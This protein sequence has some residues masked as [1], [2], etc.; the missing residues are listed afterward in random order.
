MKDLYIP[1]ESGWY[2]KRSEIEKIVIKYGVT[3][4]GDYVFGSHSNLTSVEIPNSVIDIGK[5]AFRNCTSLESVEIPNSVLNVG[6]YAFAKC[7]SLVEVAITNCIGVGMFYG[8]SNL[9]DI[10]ILDGIVSIGDDAFNGC[11]SLTKIKIPNSV[12][13]IGNSAFWGCTSLIE[14][15]VPNSVTVIGENAFNN[16]TSLTEIE[17]PNSVNC[18]KPY[19][20]CDCSNLVNVKIPDGVQDIGEYA[21]ADCIK[22]VEIKIPDHVTNIG[23]WAFDGCYS[24]KS[25]NIPQNLEKINTATFRYCA[26]TDIKIPDSVTS[27]GPRA[28]ERTKI[29]NVIIPNSV[30]VIEDRAFEY[31]GLTSAFIPKSVSNI[32]DYVFSATN[33]DLTIYGY[34][35]SYAK[36]FSNQK[37]ISFVAL[38]EGDIPSEN[39]TIIS[40]LSE[41][42]ELKAGEDNA[43]PLMYEITP[44]SSKEQDVTWTIADES[45]IKPVD[46]PVGGYWI[47]GLKPGTTTITA[48]TEDGASSTRTIT[49]ANENIGGT[50]GTTINIYT[51]EEFVCN[52]GSTLEVQANAL[53]S[54]PVEERGTIT[55]SI[56]NPA[57]L[58]EVSVK[59]DMLKG[60]STIQVKGLQSGETTLTATTS[61]GAS[62]TKTVK[63][64][65]VISHDYRTLVGT[66]QKYDA[67]TNQIYV[68]GSYYPIA[69]TVSIGDDLSS[70]NVTNMIGKQVYVLMDNGKVVEFGTI[71]S[72]KTKLDV[73]LV[74]DFAERN[75]IYQNGHYSN[76]TVPVTISIKNSVQLSG[77]DLSVI[78]KHL[79]SN[80]SLKDLCWES[81]TLE[82]Q[83]TEGI[84]GVTLAPN[85]SHSV[86]AILKIPA[87][88]V[89]ERVTEKLSGQAI[90]TAQIK[91]EACSAQ[92]GIMISVGNLDLQKEIAAVQKEQREEQKKPTSESIKNNA[93]S[94]DKELNNITNQLILPQNLDL[95]VMKD[96]QEKQKLKETIMLWLATVA[97]EPEEK[98]FTDK[99]EKE[100]YTKATKS[101]KADFKEYFNFKTFGE[102]QEWIGIG[103][104]TVQSSIR[105]RITT[106]T[107]GPQEIILTY[108]GLIMEAG[109]KPNGSMGKVT[110]EFADENAP[111]YL[112]AYAK[113]DFGMSIDADVAAFSE[114]LYD[115]AEQAVKDAWDE[116]AGDAL[117]DVASMVTS[118]LTQTIIK[119]TCGSFSDGLFD[120]ITGITKRQKINCPVDV[121][122]YDLDGNLCGSI[123]HNEVQTG[124]N[125]LYLYV[126]DDSKNVWY[127]GDDY[128]I[129]LVGNDTGT[130]DYTITEFNAENEAI[131]TVNFYNIPLTT[132][133][134]YYGIVPMETFTDVEKYQLTEQD[135]GIIT[136]DEDSYIPPVFSEEEDTVT[137]GINSL[138]VKVK[139]NKVN[140]TASVTDTATSIVTV[141][142]YY[143]DGKDVISSEM[144]YD[145]VLN[146]WHAE[147]PLVEPVQAFIMA[148][149]ANG[150]QATRGVDSVESTP[151]PVT[152]G[153]G[154]S[155]GGFSGV[156]NYPVKLN[157]TVN[158]ATVL[159]DKTNAVAGDSVTITVKP[160]AGKKVAEIVV[161]D[162]DGNIIPVT[163]A[164]DNKYRF[165]MPEGKVNVAVTTENADYDKRIVMQIN[166]KNILVDN[167]TVTND[168]APVIVGDRTMVP[169]R[170]VTELL[171][172]TA[173]W[174]EDTRT[175]TL[176]IDDK[177]LSMTIDQPIPGFGTSATIIN[178]RTYV[179]IRYVAEKLGANVEWIQAA[180]QIVIE[181]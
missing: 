93:T 146:M 76:D 35:G 50:N 97:T 125:K 147:T 159:L 175:V 129:K 164:G 140:F 179:P 74:V 14:I 31:S 118:A 78:C 42:Y 144:T 49:V 92:K 53:Y 165:T 61:D 113:N 34:T 6:E 77:C 73:N 70:I 177:V 43:I 29:S 81:P 16:C 162:T 127:T 63:V 41:T 11:T 149:N 111:E 134:I 56:G 52:V 4:I 57:V 13:T 105:V 138:A 21:F 3:S 137:I 152:P 39:G 8:C 27:I 96:S 60:C 122:V 99:L 101:L 80:A 86:K 155:S 59:T 112:K 10:R 95:Y 170:V 178:N 83:K 72:V 84:N 100:I 142:L 85:E 15:E 94:V 24:L 89:P 116:T 88:Y 55:W 79:N 123:V 168:V 40:I 71:E 19:T 141:S 48:T 130:M 110:W 124:E 38:T 18:I 143:I 133:T 161:T 157:G 64:T 20:F 115:T 156:Y 12:I 151:D 135:G 131:R 173:E 75:V 153:G 108:N 176:K 132:E 69:S 166:N 154:S 169:I 7:N 65:T 47:E 9:T 46:V 25:V 174:N 102:I 172:G 22:L 136:A 36:S 2:Q 148:V 106:E 37:G 104:R 17:I 28:F 158:S 90:V 181:K 167:R 66:L 139:D 180:Q 103:A 150:Q 160:D 171:G 62:V 145:A 120:L 58:E 44:D 30:V 128:K 109:K 82:L 33:S 54:V 126:E 67:A 114:Y 87:G 32:G 119:K 91:G 107:A 26:L 1:D 68:D 117:N 163:K 45:I 121:Y 5:Y 98:N 51:D 23:G